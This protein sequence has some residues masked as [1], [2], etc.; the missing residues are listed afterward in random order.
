MSRPGIRRLASFL[1]FALFLCFP[2]GAQDF[3]FGFGEEGEESSEASQAGSAP[4]PAV[5]ISGKVS[6][7]F[8]LYPNDFSSPETAKASD[9][10]KLFRGDLNFGASASNAEAALNF[11]L[12][13]ASL[14]DIGSRSS[15]DL[16]YNTPRLIDE[17]Y[18]RAFFGPAFSPVTVEAG[19]RKLT[20]GRADSLGPLDV[21]NPLDYSDLTR[22]TDTLDRKIARP[23]LHV[24][25]TPRAFS[26]LEAVFMPAFQGHRYELEE[27]GR[28]YPRVIGVD[29]RNDMLTGLGGA[30]G[31]LPPQ[32]A[33]PLAG[34]MGKAAGMSIEL[35]ATGG[36]EYAQ[37]GLRF[38]TLLGGADLGAQYYYGNLFRPAFTIGG[39]GKLLKA[40]AES[41]LDSDRITAAAGELGLHTAYNRY[42][43]AGLDYAQVLAGFNVRA[44]FAAHITEDLGGDD[45]EVYNPSLAWSFGFDRDLLGFTLNLQVNESI[46]LMDG[47]VN[48]NPAL[49]TEA[50]MASTATTFTAQISR[51]FLRDKLE[52]KFTH[53]W[54]IEAMDIYYIPS[55]TYTAGDLSTEISGGVFGGKRGGEFSQY[56]EMGFVRTALT[57]S[58]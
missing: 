11:R 31:G 38:T 36:L 15:N 18:L 25:W 45:G 23:M 37:A 33:V 30:L 3:G 53:I 32:M 21:T 55:L 29:R 51:K 28:W 2:L 7:A 42:H 6:A 8:E 13:A 54:N 40:A 10:G 50:G 56:R 24:S 26:K 46:R 14:W 48:G 43:Q 34:I 39:A 1:A 57:Y 41:P 47:Q 12:S 16:L 4:P 58:F 9:L 17:A 5:H 52:L 44:E 35:P 20:W 19:F 22:I 49:D 27:T